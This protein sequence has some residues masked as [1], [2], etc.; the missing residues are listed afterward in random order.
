MRHRVQP[1]HRCVRPRRP[2]PQQLAWPRRDRRRVIVGAPGVCARR[3]T[4]SAH[5]LR[6]AHSP[7]TIRQ[8]RHL[9]LAQDMRGPTA[10]QFLRCRHRGP[11]GESRCRPDEDV[12]LRRQGRRDQLDDAGELLNLEKCMAQAELGDRASSRVDHPPCCGGAAA[13]GLQD[14]LA[15]RRRRL[16]RRRIRRDSSSRTTSRH[17]PPA[18][19]T[20]LGPQNAASGAFAS[21]AFTRRCSPARRAAVRASSKAISQ[22]ADSPQPS[23]AAGPHSVRLGFPCGIV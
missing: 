22:S 7:R 20:G 10:L 4:P 5:G 13:E 15:S 18:R 3:L 23:E 9:C 17:R 14:S 12:A 21:T 11:Y 6:D 8:H 1:T 16:D 2:Q 19:G